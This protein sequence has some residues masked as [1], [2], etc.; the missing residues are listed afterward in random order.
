M[1][2]E[3]FVF[4][5]AFRYLWFI[6]VVKISHQIMKIQLYVS[7]DMLMDMYRVETIRA[8]TINKPTF[9]HRAVQLLGT[10]LWRFERW[11]CGDGLRRHSGYV[12]G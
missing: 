2:K 3:T 5:L 1:H 7:M 10:G 11:R 12:R 6:V 8:N 9:F 4:S